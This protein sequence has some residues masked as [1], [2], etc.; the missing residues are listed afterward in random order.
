MNVASDK[1]RCGDDRLVSKSGIDFMWGD[2]RDGSGTSRTG[3]DTFVFSPGGGAGDKICDFRQADKDKIDVSA[4]G[5]DELA[6]MNLVDQGDNILIEFSETDAVL[7]KGFGDPGQ[8][9]ERDFVFADKDD[10]EDREKE[11][12][13]KEKDKREKKGRND[14]DRDVEDDDDDKDA[15][16]NAASIVELFE[17]NLNSPSYWVRDLAFDLDLFG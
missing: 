9:T 5:F 15:N 8:V 13:E 3:A 11:K 2:Y 16:E 7:L 17:A 10:P 4:Y 1:V 6:D 14:D 12:K